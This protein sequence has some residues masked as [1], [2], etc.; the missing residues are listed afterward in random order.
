[1]DAEELVAF[2]DDYTDAWLAGDDPLPEPL[3]RWWDSYKGTGKGEPTRE[4]FAEP[5]IGPLRSDAA[6]VTLGLNPGQAFPELQGRE[7]A[8]GDEIRRAGSYSAWAAENPYL[9]LTWQKFAGR[10]NRYHTARQRFAQ[11]WTEAGSDVPKVLTLELFPWHSTEV[12]AVMAP[13]LD[14]IRDFVWEPLADLGCEI[15]FAFGRPWSNVCERLQLKPLREW[16]F[17]K[18]SFPFAVSSRVARTFELPTRGQVCIT[19]QVGYAGP[20]GREDAR[21]L[22][23]AL[24]PDG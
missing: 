11:H 8:F 4:C 10:P 7:G 1:M 5:Y 22:R 14:I 21:R 9:G 2:W 24:A 6:L 12:T 3:S 20:P 18:A 23:E 17:G 13:P 19:W 16:R 15:L